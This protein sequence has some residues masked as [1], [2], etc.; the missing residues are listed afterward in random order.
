[1]LMLQQL[2][3][4]SAELATNDDITNQR[5]TISLRKI[6]TDK[7]YKFTDCLGC[8]SGVQEKSFL[9]HVDTQ[10]QLNFLKYIG[11]EV[12]NQECI[13]YRDSNGLFSLEYNDKSE[14][15]GKKFKELSE[16]EA[17]LRGNYTKIL[18]RG[19]C[20]IVE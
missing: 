2:V 10:D 11:I 7:H 13:L 9:V 12:F 19:I 14:I 6:L 17:K 5:N 4:L 16:S 1:M 15:I 8:Y 3:I 20:F 18:P